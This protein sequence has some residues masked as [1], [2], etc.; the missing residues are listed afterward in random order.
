M[1][2]AK[3]KPAPRTYPRPGTPGAAATPAEAHA[4]EAGDGALTAE[5]KARLAEEASREEDA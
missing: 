4:E 1:T 3:A 5:E 2:S